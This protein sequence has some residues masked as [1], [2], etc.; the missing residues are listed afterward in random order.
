[1]NRFWS[2]IATIA[3]ATTL[4]GCSGATEPLG[5]HAEFGRAL[6]LAR[7]PQAYSFDVAVTAFFSAP[8]YVRV[9]VS[10]GQ[11]VDARDSSGQTVA[12]FNLTI[13]DIWNN[14][15]A[16]RVRNEVNAIRF[17]ERGVPVEADIGT[18]ANDG[19][20][21]YSVRNFAASR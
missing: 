1:M 18:W 4:L 9:R 6:W 19:G 7:R 13:D 15:E 14:V 10:D 11:A 5:N 8:G 3:V 2:R 12:N 17:D 21:H 16:A 20:V